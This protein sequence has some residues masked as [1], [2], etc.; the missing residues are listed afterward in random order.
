[1]AW[2]SVGQ[3]VRGCP[4]RSRGR[5]RARR[6]RV[7]CPWRPAGWG[8]NGTLTPAGC[9]TGCAIRRREQRGGRGRWSNRCGFS[10][11]VQRQAVGGEAE[12]ALGVVLGFGTSH[13]CA[14]L[15]LASEAIDR[16]VREAEIGCVD[17]ACHDPEHVAQSGRRARCR[18]PSPARRRSRGLRANS[19][20]SAQPVPTGRAAALFD[21]L[22]QP[23]GV[24]DQSVKPRR[25]APPGASRIS[26]LPRTSSRGLGQASVS[27]RIRSP[28]PAAR[29]IAC[30]EAGVLTRRLPRGRASA[31]ASIR[32]GSAAPARTSARAPWPK[33]AVAVRRRRRR[34]VTPRS[35]GPGVH[36]E[37]RFGQQQRGVR[38]PGPS[39]GREPWTCRPP[40][41]RPLHRLAAPGAELGPSDSQRSS[42]RHWYRSAVRCRPRMG[43]NS[44]AKPGTNIT[45]CWPVSRRVGARPVKSPGSPAPQPFPFPSESPPHMA[46]PTP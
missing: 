27:G 9:R 16:G 3:A 14:S 2:C 36:A 24:D 15:P 8:A 41:A 38:P 21:L 23:G 7:H 20:D 12:V 17:V 18:R 19:A 37:V 10:A 43:S 42:Q 29:I 25:P 40:A 31:A 44:R 1:L 39:S 26:G 35:L 4:H 32:A 45:G 28:R 46:K 6:S 22:A 30:T 11:A 5:C 33:V 34:R 13:R